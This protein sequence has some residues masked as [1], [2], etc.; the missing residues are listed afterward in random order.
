MNLDRS[1]S[2]SPLAVFVTE[3]RPWVARAACR[4]MPVEAFFPPQSDKLGRA[5]ALAVCAR[6]PVRRECLDWALEVDEPDGIFG[7][8][9]PAQRRQLARGH[10]PQP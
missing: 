5:V 1:P 7:G 3:L 6:C 9:V 4:E 2:P 8:T 10:R